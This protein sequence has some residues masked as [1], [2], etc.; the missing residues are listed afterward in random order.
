MSP[1]ADINS[2]W[3]SIQ[4]VNPNFQY[5]ATTMV[6]LFQHVFSATMMASVAKAVLPFGHLGPEGTVLYLNGF[7]FLSGNSSAEISANHYCAILSDD[8]LQCVVYTTNTTPTHL[9]GIEYIISPTLFETL[10]MEERQLWHSHAYEVASGFLVE[11]NMPAPIDHSIMEVL[12]GTYGKTVHTWRYD[13][14][15]KV[16]PVGI[17]ELVMGYTGDGQI[18]PDFVT[19]RDQLFGL[20][21]TE[22]RES[23]SDI[24]APIVLPG[25]DS[26]TNGYVLTY[27][28]VNTTNET[29]FEN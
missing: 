25:A 21:T 3:N 2:P 28:L 22:I 16:V 23:R 17:P 20:N 18:T 4:K 10:D 14:K 7:H 9:A 24:K 29:V 26:W 5:P 1:F 11:P 27:G 6:A 12:V 15:D 13:A 8:F 19:N